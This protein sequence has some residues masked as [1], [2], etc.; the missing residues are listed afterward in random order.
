MDR[1]SPHRRSSPQRRTAA[2]ARMKHRGAFASS[3]HRSLAF[4]QVPARHPPWASWPPASCCCSSCQCWRPWPPWAWRRGSWSAPPSAAH[5]VGQ[6]RLVAAH[7]HR[8][9]YEDRANMWQHARYELVLQTLLDSAHLVRRPFP[10][11]TWSVATG[12]AEGAAAW[13]TASCTAADCFAPCL[14][15]CLRAALAVFFALLT[16]A[17]RHQR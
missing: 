13:A 10:E 14:A 5:R 15:V 2:L 6:G 1:A 11:R 9:A 17:C 16:R 4:P 3:R 8:T 12:P 7:G